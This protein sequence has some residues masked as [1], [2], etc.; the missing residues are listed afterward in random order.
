MTLD[1]PSSAEPGADRAGT[2]DSC[3]DT[4]DDLVVVTRLYVVP[5]SWDSEPSVTES[6]GSESWC[7]PCR[8]HYP[9]REA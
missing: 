8:T 5:E 7:F 2:C 9:H 6:E 1:P 3:G 4:V